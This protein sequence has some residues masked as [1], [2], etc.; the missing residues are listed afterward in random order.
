MVANPTAGRRA[1]PAEAVLTIGWGGVGRVDLEPAG[2]GDPECEADHGYTGVLAS[3]DFS[4]RVSRRGRRRRRGRRPARLRRARCPRAPHG[5]SADR[6][7]RRLRRA[8][9]R[10]PRRS[11][12]SLP[13]VAA[14]ARRR[15]R[16]CRRPALVLPEAPVVRRLPGRRPRRPSCCARHAA[17]GAVPRL[18]ARRPAEPGTAGVPSTTATS[19]TSLGTGLTPGHARAGRLH[20]A[21]PR[22][23]PA[24]QRA[25]AGT[26]TS[27]RCE[28]QPHPTAFARL[29]RRRACTSTV[30]NKR[31]FAGSGLTVAGAARRRRTS[32]PTGSASG[33]RPRSS[34]ARTRPSLTY[35]YDGDLDWT[36]HRYGVAS[37]PW[38]QQ[39]AMV[40][41]E[42]EQ[43]REALPADVAAASWSPTTAW[44]TRPPR[45]GSTSTTTPSC[46]TGVA[47][48]RRRGP[49]PPPL[50]P[51]RRRRR[52]GRRPGASVLGDRA[53]VLTRDERDRARLVRRRS[54][55]RVRPRLGDVVVA[56]RGDTAVVSSQPTSPT[57]PRWSGCTA[58]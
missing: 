58:R 12:T 52:R 29:R 21:G 47:A 41:A 18:A 45:A 25:A 51:R 54:A 32:A 39:L 8:G 31:E 57:R 37:T 56:C 15:R 16:R 22:H 44:S 50:L 4:L 14:R 13:A 33:S 30:V 43:L 11:A 2:C 27:T 9:L 3:D 10:R 40:D 55:P 17:R 35:L 6:L 5:V 48:A 42:A 49:V 19:L 36:G 7:S 20:L 46:A 53:E 1:R 34:A 28:W 38:L 23:R 26:R 24:A